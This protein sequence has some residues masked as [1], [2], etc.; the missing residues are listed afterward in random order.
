MTKSYQIHIFDQ[1][2]ATRVV[3][4]EN[5]FNISIVRE[6]SKPCQIDFELPN[7]DS[8]LD[9][10]FTDSQSVLR[11][12]I[13]IGNVVE[14]YDDETLEFVGIISGPL[15]KT[16]NP[17][18]V[19]AYG[20]AI[21]LDRYRTPVLW[22]YEDTPANILRQILKEHRFQRRTTNADFDAGTFNQTQRIDLGGSGSGDEGGAVILGSDGGT[23]PAPPYY[24]SGDWIS[25]VID[26]S[27]DLTAWRKIKFKAGFGANT[28]I[29]FQTRT[30]PVTPPDVSW[31][32][33]TIAVSI[34]E[35]SEDGYPI[36]ST[37]Q[38][39][40]QVKLN[41]TT[42]NTDYSSVIHALEVQGTYGNILTEGTGFAD[43]PTDNISYN[44]TYE[45][46]LKL[47]NAL[48]A[49]QGKE[50]LESGVYV[51]KNA[52]WEE[53]IAGAINV[54]VPLGSDKAAQYTFHEY[55][56]FEM[57]EY[58]EDDTDLVNYVIGLGTGTG[59]DQLMEVAQDTDSQNRYGKRVGFY[60]SAT[61]KTGS[62]LAD[63]TT[64]YLNKYKD[65]KRFVQIRLI[66]TPDGTWDFKAGDTVRLISPNHSL[67]A[68]LRIIRE[69]RQFSEQ[70]FS[71]ELTLTN[72][73]PAVQSFV[74][75]YLEERTAF[76]LSAD[77][78]IKN[79]ESGDLWTAWISTGDV[80]WHSITIQLGF[81]PTDGN[82]LPIQVL[83]DVTGYYT[84]PGVQIDY[85]VSDLRTGEMEFEYRQIDAGGANRIR[86]QFLWK[87][88]SR[89]RTFSSIGLGGQI[90]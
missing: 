35:W 4:L 78:A 81:T 59:L 71:I 10:T 80:A 65:P 51:W 68:S 63:A 24:A 52:E 37:A 82:I 39:Y 18:R 76:A 32:A 33:W 57:L 19:T 34:D 2:N 30:G 20:L 48:V 1:D 72:P 62:G 49:E 40:I 53:T 6:V 83:E 86:V 85:R 44:P 67:D 16:V 22:N 69:I 74:S 77:S 73:M 66:D 70:R 84:Q 38:R 13:D 25:S 23:P 27:T 31:E 64:G 54:A 36:T 90:S 12:V 8:K 42:S 5:A 3:V 21:K 15:D 88:W 56:H 45:S 29:T 47:L 26:M 60:E 41:F 79:F 7:T 50:V 61:E 46:H 11:P 14:V 58:E 43:L 28:S 9:E 55:Q 17:V 87:A 89:R 75:E